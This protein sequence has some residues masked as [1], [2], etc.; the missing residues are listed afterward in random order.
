MIS[1]DVLLSVFAPYLASMGLVLCA[2]VVLPWGYKLWRLLAHEVPMLSSARRVKT[3]A[4]QAARLRDAGVS[5]FGA[6]P[7]GDGADWPDLS[8]VER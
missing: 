8:G 2:V 3:P 4:G 1:A 6:A 5:P 7:S